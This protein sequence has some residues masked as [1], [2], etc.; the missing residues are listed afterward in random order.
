[1]RVIQQDNSKDLMFKFSIPIRTPTPNQR[2]KAL[3]GSIYVLN[4][5]GLEG[6]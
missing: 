5:F 1:V 4:L 3:I 6:M 2:A